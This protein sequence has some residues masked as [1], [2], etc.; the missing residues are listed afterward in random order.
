MTLRA[1]LPKQNP[2]CSNSLR[3]FF[4]RIAPSTSSFRCLANLRVHG[5][6]FRAL[7]R[8]RFASLLSFYRR[9]KGRGKEK[10]PQVETSSTDFH[11]RPRKSRPTIVPKPLISRD[12]PQRNRNWWLLSFSPKPGEMRSVQPEG[13]FQPS[14]GAA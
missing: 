13:K 2:S 8:R 5:L 4:Q 3:I 12:T 10:G 11:R 6:R 7:R 1:A 9:E 14:T